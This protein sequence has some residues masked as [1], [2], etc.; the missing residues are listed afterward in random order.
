MTEYTY[1]DPYGYDL[2]VRTSTTKQG[3]VKVWTVDGDPVD[4]PTADLPKV[5]GELY[6]AA[7]LPNPLAGHPG[8]HVMQSVVDRRDLV[9]EPS[10]RAEGAVYFGQSSAR[11]WHIRVEDL[12]ELVSALYTAAG[13]QPPILLPPLN[14]HGDDREG[15]VFNGVS[16]LRTGKTISILGRTW[17][18]ETARGVARVLAGLADAADAEPDPVA[19]QLL[20]DVVDGSTPLSRDDAETIARAVLA[21]GYTRSES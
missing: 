1:T 5:V 3:D 9:I 20:A 17:N 14:W 4:I 16:A 7:G 11:G 19:L 2:H 6:K 12:P 8:Q 21:A 18:A 13:Q 10:I 15:F